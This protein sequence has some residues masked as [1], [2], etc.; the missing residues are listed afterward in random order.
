MQL[1]GESEGKEGKGLIPS[2]LYFTQ[3]LHSMGQLLQE[4][5]KTFFET[6]I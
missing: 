3:D 5:K 6:T 4:G 2:K 1:F